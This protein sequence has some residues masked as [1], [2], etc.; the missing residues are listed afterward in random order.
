MLDILEDHLILGG[1]GYE[2]LDGASM[3]PG[4]SVGAEPTLIF[5]V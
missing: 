5:A 4:R 2:R 1:F 3:T